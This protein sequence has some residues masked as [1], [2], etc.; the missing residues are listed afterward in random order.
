[1]VRKRGLAWLLIPPLATATCWGFL[2]D[3]GGFENREPPGIGRHQP[4]FDSI[5]HHFDEVAGAIRPAMQISLLVFIS[6]PP[7]KA[8]KS[9]SALHAV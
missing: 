7:E 8:S 4:V 3:I 6:E 1:M 5:V 2:A 9:C